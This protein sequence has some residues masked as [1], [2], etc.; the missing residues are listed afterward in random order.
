MKDIDYAARA[1]LA[2]FQEK[3]GAQYDL[4]SLVVEPLGAR[5]SVR[6]TGQQREATR[7]KLMIAIR[8]AN[9]PG[10]VFAQDESAS[11]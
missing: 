2:A 6:F 7:D 8:K 1:V 9:E 11:P 3:F 5:I 10:D 4:R